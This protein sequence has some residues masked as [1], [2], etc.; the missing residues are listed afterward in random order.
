MKTS[1]VLLMALGAVVLAGCTLASPPPPMPLIQGL[2]GTPAQIST[3]FGQ[4][5]ESLYPAGSDSSA[6]F[7]ELVNEGFAARLASGD[8]DALELHFD[9]LRQATQDSCTGAWTVSWSASDGKITQ[10][11][12]SYA[13]R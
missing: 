10:L 2:A 8:P 9:A 11:Q 13:C 5:L 6:L 12:G 4:R 1:S 7:A 3:D